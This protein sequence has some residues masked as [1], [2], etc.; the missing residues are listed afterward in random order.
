MHLARIFPR[1]KVPALEVPCE[2]LTLIAA[3]SSSPVPG[4]G[5]GGGWGE[6]NQ[7]TFVGEETLRNGG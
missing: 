1:F 3:N 6:G 7:Q 5:G 2:W 4:G